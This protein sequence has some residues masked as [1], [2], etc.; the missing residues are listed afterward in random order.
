R[1]DSRRIEITR[2]ARELAEKKLETETERLRLGLTTTHQVLEFQK[3]LAEARS[4][5]LRAVTDLNKSDANLSR[6][7][8][9]LLEERG[10]A[11]E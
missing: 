2:K 4:R 8:G 9:T 11:L 7:K 10:I 6:V 5:E 3:D 1:T